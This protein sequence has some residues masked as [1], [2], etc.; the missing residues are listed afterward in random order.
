MVSSLPRARTPQRAHGGERALLAAPIATAVQDADAQ[1][2][3]AGHLQRHISA[4]VLLRVLQ[5]FDLRLQLSDLGAQALPI[6]GA[7][8]SSSSSRTSFPTCSVVA[9]RLFLGTTWN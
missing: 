4:R 7:Q 2:H 6:L 1:P 8:P 9:L 5:R 3:E